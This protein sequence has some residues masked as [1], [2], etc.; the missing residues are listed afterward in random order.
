M[1]L[2]DTKMVKGHPQYRV[3]RRSPNPHA[4]GHV[5]ITLAADETSKGPR[6]NV[7]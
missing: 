3:G 2:P 6:G 7:G 4:H 5:A 1:H